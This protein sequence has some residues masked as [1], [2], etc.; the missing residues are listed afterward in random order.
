MDDFYFDH[1]DFYNP[2]ENISYWNLI[3]GMEGKNIF[4]A[5]HKPYTIK[6]GSILFIKPW[7]YAF[8]LR[9]QEPFQYRCYTFDKIT[10]SILHTIA[11]YTYIQLPEE[12]VHRN[13]TLAHIIAACTE[14]KY[15]LGK[16]EYP[17]LPKIPQK[18]L[19]EIQTSPPESV[20]EWV[21]KIGVSDR[22]LETHFRR[23]LNILPGHYL[24]NTK[25]CLSRQKSLVH[26]TKSCYNIE[27]FS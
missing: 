17:V 8:P 9:A 2:G 15:L 13:C 19:T 4:L 22:T 11:L 6:P 21:S 23:T 7:D 14:T 24:R 1:T 20:K 16:K 12:I 3:V 18:A 10:C 5:N 25:Y 27:K 26:T